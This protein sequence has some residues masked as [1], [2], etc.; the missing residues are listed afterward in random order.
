MGTEASTN[1][2]LRFSQVIDAPV[3]RAWEVVAAVSGVDKWIPF[4]TSCR[5]E[6]QGAGARRYCETADGN[7][8]TERVLAIVPETRT[9]WYAIE[10]GL[11]VSRYE[12]LMQFVPDGELR[13]RMV[14]T[15]T[16]AGA[17]A[18]SA[19]VASMLEQ[20]AP[21]VFIGLAAHLGHARA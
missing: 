20:A 7:A 9:F 19:G 13:C 14:W 17:E 6:G 15:V 5:V 3:E 1:K 16:F 21:A 11:P 2:T 4:I 18:A 12:G 10:A 8:L